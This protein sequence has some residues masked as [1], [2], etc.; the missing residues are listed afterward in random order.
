MAPEILTEMFPQ[1]E[2][3]CS[4]IN[5]TTLQVEVLKLSYM[6]QKLYLVWDQKRKFVTG[7]QRIVHVVY[8]KDMYKTFDFCKLPVRTYIVL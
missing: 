7:L 5:S 2:S 1:K 8:V 3:N 4:L 6:A